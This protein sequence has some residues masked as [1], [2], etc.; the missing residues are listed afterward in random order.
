[1]RRTGMTRRSR[2]VA[3]AATAWLLLA[4]LGR[5]AVAA[6]N[7]TAW[8]RWQS[9][10]ARLDSIETSARTLSGLAELD[11][12]RAALLDSL[13]AAV[14]RAGDPDS[15]STRTGTIDG[16]ADGPA[17][18]QGSEALAWVRR[19]VLDALFLGEPRPTRLLIEA[20]RHYQL[21]EKRFGSSVALNERMRAILRRLDIPE[22][23]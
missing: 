7:A 14:G 21:A 2:M 6:S 12:G 11:A 22:Y 8:A 9:V 13:C 15:G 16:P 19:T 18:P 20:R 5:D 23:R 1:M 4:A 3:A 10:W 17:L